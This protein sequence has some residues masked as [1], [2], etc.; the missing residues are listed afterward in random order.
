MSWIASAFVMLSITHDEQLWFI[1]PI[2]SSIHRQPARAC[3][4]IKGIVANT[5]HVGQDKHMG[6]CFPGRLELGNNM[7]TDIVI[8][9]NFFIQ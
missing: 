9:N 4:G 1:K 8:I 5:L 3:V 6:M 7:P 2:Q